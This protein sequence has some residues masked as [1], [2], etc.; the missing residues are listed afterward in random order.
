MSDTR[1]AAHLLWATVAAAA[2][3]LGLS[4]PAVASPR[5]PCAEVTY[6]GVCV[7]IN[8]RTSTPPRH[9]H[10]EVPVQFQDTAG[11]LPGN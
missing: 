5:G 11:S 2:L 3:A 1:R 6:V 9:S 10:G 4:A 8:D 7:P